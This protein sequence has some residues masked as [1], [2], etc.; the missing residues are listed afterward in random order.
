MSLQESA[1][2]ASKLKKRLQ[3]ASGL[4][5][6][7]GL[8]AA[9]LIYRAADTGADEAVAYEIIIGQAYSVAPTDSKLYNRELERIGGK[10]ALLFADFDRWFA[11]L[12]RGRS[13]AFTVAF[14]TAT[15]SAGLFLI[16]RRC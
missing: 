10:A 11:G 14:L 4:I 1:G 9:V 16:A 6:V 13:L 7:L 2:D 3:L 8:C 15:A 12:W 5:L